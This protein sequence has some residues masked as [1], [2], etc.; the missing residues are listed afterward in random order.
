M[1]RTPFVLRASRV[2]KLLGCIA[3]AALPFLGF[4][5][6]LTVTDP[7]PKIQFDPWK[8]IPS[9][10]NTLEYTESFPSAIQSPYP[11]NN[12]VP[13]HIMIPAQNSGP[14]PA[15]IVLH[16]W[17][18][19]DLQ[20]EEELA[21]ELND[22]GMAAVIMTL[23]Y[24]LSRTPKGSRSGKM[25]VG[26][27]VAALVQTMTQSVLDVRR[28]LDFLE[29]RPEFDHSR[30]GVAGISLGSIVASIA[31]GV[32]DRI[33]QGALLLGGADLAH[34]IWHSSR[35]GAVREELRHRGY[36]E[37]RLRIE[38]NP[39][40]AL[41]FLPSRHGEN[42]LVVGGKYDTVMPRADTQKLIDALP[43]AQVLWLD[44]GHY[45]GVFVE[46]RLLRTAAEFFAKRFAGQAYAAPK[47]VYAPTLRLGAIADTSSGL[48]LGAGIDLFKP[49]PKSHF[50]STIIVTPKGLNLFAGFLLG[51]GLAVG[52]FATPQRVSVGA[53][54]SIVL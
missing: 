38:L 37:A 14:M 21:R 12:V 27:D 34:I 7:L 49:N 26:S 2:A 43:G 35:T 5:Q 9:D 30:F 8:A 45:G 29:T 16:Y 33:K 31:F 42:A 28:S 10:E 17:G 11:E 6:A 15:V 1:G 36:T 13:L 51:Q 19:T 18:A 25:A 20:V 39:V 24:H 22:H 46:K 48:Q 23:P 53:W 52:G 54:W 40:D 50:L 47:H 3:L 4:G 44:T 41:R 32:D